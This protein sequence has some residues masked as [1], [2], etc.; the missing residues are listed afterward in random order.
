MY[1]AKRNGFFSYVLYC[2]LEVPVRVC[3]AKKVR[4]CD[5]LETKKGKNDGSGR[6]LCEC[7]SSALG[8]TTKHKYR[9]NLS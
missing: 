3:S 4:N 5:F 9:P 2:S 6:T 7:T 8:D 1:D